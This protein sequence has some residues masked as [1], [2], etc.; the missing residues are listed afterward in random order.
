MTVEQKRTRKSFDYDIQEILEKAKWTASAERVRS[1]YIKLDTRGD[2][3]YRPVLSADDPPVPFVI[4]YQHWVDTDRYGEIPIICPKKHQEGDCYIC[5]TYP[6]NSI[7][8]SWLFPV[9]LFDN[10]SRSWDSEVQ[11]I[12]LSRT[13]GEELFDEICEYGTNAWK[14][15]SDFLIVQRKSGGPRGEWKIKLASS[16]IRSNLP[17]I[18]ADV[19]QSAPEISQIVF[20]S[21]DEM[22]RKVEG[23][24]DRKVGKAARDDDDYIPPK[25]NV[26]ACQEEEDDEDYIPPKRKAA[27]ARMVEDDDYVS[28]KRK[29]AMVD[30]AEYAPKVKRKLVEV[31]AVKD[32]EEEEESVSGHRRRDFF[33]DLDED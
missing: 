20:L 2:N 10:D 27:A 19:L 33:E 3:F 32:V 29:L 8:A 9:V 14:R 13:R 6:D 22:R 31:E 28:A 7:K 21:Y 15:Q 24:D 4:L 23:I 1:R 5:D 30:H 18:P 25:R 26:V 12:S 17:P 16:D 11:L